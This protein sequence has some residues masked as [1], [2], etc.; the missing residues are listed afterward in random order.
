VNWFLIP[1]Y[2]DHD[3]GT[4]QFTRFTFR[5]LHEETNFLDHSPGNTLIKKFQKRSTKFFFGRHKPDR[6]L[7]SMSFEQHE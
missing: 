1:D 2:P 4:R 7:E 5:I 3:N 6:L